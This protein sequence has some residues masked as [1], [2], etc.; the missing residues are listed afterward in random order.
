MIK[1]RVA[2]SHTGGE[3][4]RVVLPGQFE[5]NATTMQGR[6]EELYS[7]HADLTRA[8]V[9]EPRGSSAWVGAVMTP[10]EHPDSDCGII[11]FNQTGPLGMCG[12]GTIGVA[13]TIRFLEGKQDAELRFDTGVGTVCVTPHEDGDFSFENVVS[14]RK[15]TDVPIEVPS[16][17]TVIGDVAYGGNWF[18][19]VRSLILAPDDQDS[20]KWTQLTLAIL[21]AVRQAGYPEVDHVEVFGPSRIPGRDSRSFVLCPSGGYDRSP[22]GTGTSAKLACLAADGL[23][24]EGE[25]W[26]QESFVGSVFAGSI[27]AVE[28]G[29]VPRIRGRAHMMGLGEV[30]FE[31]TDPFRWGI[32]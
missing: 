26:F 10:A 3:P 30:C 17:G 32:A 28:G 22:C 25:T 7:M 27:R 16:L 21:G 1:I 5:F 29:V 23:L 31:S 14:Y 9:S 4:T 13:E 19:L 24:T 18:F 6:M 12:H 11:F 2:D 20:V 8:L 15:A